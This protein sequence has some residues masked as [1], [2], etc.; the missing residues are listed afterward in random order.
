[1]NVDLASGDPELQRMKSLSEYDF[2]HDYVI[3]LFKE[4]GLREVRYT[5][6][7]EEYGRDIICYKFDNFGYR[8]DVAVQVKINDIRRTRVVQ[9]VIAEAI[10]AYQNAF[11]DT[12]THTERQIS[13][14]Y[15]V[16]SGEIPEYSK[17]QIKNGLILLPTIHFMDGYKILDIRKKRLSEYLKFSIVEGK[18]N[19]ISIIELCNDNRFLER[20]EGML[21]FLIDDIGSSPLHCINLLPSVLKADGDISSKIDPL[22]DFD[23]NSILHWLSIYLITRAWYI[24]GKNKKFGLIEEML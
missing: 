22:G 2:T 3:P 15:V 6:G 1:M 9:E 16:T 20:A 18:M 11:I 13:L 8:E 4:M 23:R 17:G 5:G 7:N 24:Y 10:A 21:K 14:L 12:Y 19:D